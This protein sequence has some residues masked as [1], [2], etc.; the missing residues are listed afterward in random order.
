ML[1]R[2]FFLLIVAIIPYVIH[3]MPDNAAEDYAAKNESKFIIKPYLQFATQTS[4]IILWETDETSSAVVQFCNELPFTNE[5]EKKE[6]TAFHKVEL[7]GLSPET[8]YFYRVV[9]ITDNGTEIISQ[10]YTFKTVVK[11]S[12]SFAF[13]IIGDTQNNIDIWGKIA[14]LCW[15]E[16]PNFGIHVGDIV[17]T[18]SDKSQ[19][20]NEF[21]APGNIFMSRYPIY[22]AIGNHEANHGNYYKY[23]ANPNNST[24]YTYTYGNAQF[25]VI[26]SNF[27]VSTGSAQYQWIKEELAKSTAKWKIA[28]HHHPP[29]TSDNDDYGDTSEEQSDLGDQRLRPLTVLYEK[30]RVNV[31][32]FGH[33]HDYERTWPIYEDKIDEARGV[34]YI[35]TGGAGGGL[36]DYAPTRSWFT[37]KVKRSHHYCLAVVNNDVMEFYAIDQ[38][39]VL[40]DRLDIKLQQT[41]SVAN[42]ENTGA[43][44]YSLE[45]VYPNPFNPSTNIKF[46]IP[47]DSQVVMTIYNALG[48]EVETLINE[49]LNAGQHSV[50]W[51]ASSS[52]SSGVYICRMSAAG[53]NGETF[54]SSKKLILLR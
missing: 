10:V 23:M 31:V 51:N 16:R 13:V 19:W 48:Q 37:A 21:F 50:K 27:D 52:C 14:K 18:G 53:K 24:Y 1:K 30:Y 26:N 6:T 5:Y 15:Q 41:I 3:A 20:V 43:E 22:S 25:F 2:I 34:T 39:G 49:N 35:Q 9:S 36:E 40:F 4:I 54:A 12:S 11:D 45:D 8:N 46:S 29:Y 47:F 7:T 28:Y 32:F 38:N 33:I 17:G 42:T 44:I